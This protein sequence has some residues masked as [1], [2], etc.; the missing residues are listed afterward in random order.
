M[1]DRDG[2]LGMSRGG[3]GM[4][5]AAN[6][7][8]SSAR[9]AARREEDLTHASNPQVPAFWA[10]DDGVHPILLWIAAAHAAAGLF[11]ATT[12]ALVWLL[13]EPKVVPSPLDVYHCYSA[14]G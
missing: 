6:G 2:W 13:S 7:N 4:W 5:M 11:G 10:R 9:V 14:M 8:A 12:S 1:T 3:S